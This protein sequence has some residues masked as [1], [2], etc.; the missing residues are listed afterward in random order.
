MN[1]NPTATSSRF[2]RVGYLLL[3][4][5]LG[6]HVFC[7]FISPGAMPPV[8]PLM[9]RGYRLARPYNE[10]MFLNHGYHYFAPDPGASTLIRWT[11]PRE[12]EASVVGRFPSTDIQPRLLYHRY[13]ML[14][15]NL[16]AFDEETQRE[17]QEAYAR[18]FAR[19]QNSNRVRLEQ[20][21]HEPS[22]LVRILAGGQLDDPE[23]FSSEVMGDYDFSRSPALLSSSAAPSDG[24]F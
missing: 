14:A 1:C 23:M 4:T 17:M 6:W 10:L 9:E 21:L 18:H 11:V 20:I 12:G 3:S 13:F 24:G 16:W 2:S 7:V 22:P 19:L 5:W 8:S 15:E